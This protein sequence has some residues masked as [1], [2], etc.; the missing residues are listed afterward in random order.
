MSQLSQTARRNMAVVS[1]ISLLVMTCIDYLTGY[2]LVFSA[3]Y[4]IPVSL[5]A[6]YFGRRAIWSM[7][8]ASG[9]ASL[10]ADMGHPYSHFMLQY[11]NSFTCFLI[12]LI[13]GLLL[14]RFKSTLEERKQMNHDLQ[15]A[16]EELKNSTEE[17][18]KLQNGLQVVCA[19]TK[20]IKVGEQW[21]S[22]DEFLR[23][24]LHLK[25][26]HGMSPKAK[27]EFEQE[28]KQHAWAAEA[29]HE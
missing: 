3:A 7:S 10:F 29:R 22:P 19:W 5:C 27:L 20:Q 8:I 13:T 23:T 4:L 15:K 6:W 1:I 28:I 21:M 18:T 9:L 12:S 25:I 16:L 14:H 2:E 24:Q 11:F 26:S 17:I